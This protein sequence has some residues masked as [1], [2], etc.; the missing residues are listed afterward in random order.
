M[1]LTGAQITAFFKKADQMAIPNAAV[2]QLIV[3]G[4]NMVDDLSEFDKDTIQQIASNLRRPPAGNPFVFGAK[5]QKRLIAACEIVRFYK[6]VGRSLTAANIMWNT[7]IKN[8]EIQWKALKDKK[9]GDEP[10]TP[11]IAK[12]LNIMKWS[13]SFRDILHRCIGVQMIPLAYVIRELEVPP[14]IT[15]L[16]AGQPHSAELVLSSKN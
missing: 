6:T 15:T 13:E 5:S 4:I 14:A 7:V 10:E 12:G 9:D 16:T 8:F 1:V 2:M 3:E 11:K